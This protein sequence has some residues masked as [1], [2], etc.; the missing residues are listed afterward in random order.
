M[1]FIIN[2]CDG[3]RI[4]PFPSECRFVRSWESKSS[5]V[6]VQDHFY[7]NFV[8]KNCICDFSFAR[9]CQFFVQGRVNFSFSCCVTPFYPI[10]R[11]YNTSRLVAEDTTFT[12]KQAGETYKNHLH[13]H[14]VVLKDVNNIF[15]DIDPF[16]VE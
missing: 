14:V 16:V 9:K 6:K 2:I 15:I 13:H 11:F 1:T 8:L 10:Y 4:K 3:C 5:P 12:G 7:L